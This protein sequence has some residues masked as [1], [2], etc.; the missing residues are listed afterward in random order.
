MEVDASHDKR[1]GIIIFGHRPKT[2][3]Y[4][5]GTM[6]STRTISEVK[7]SFIRNQVR[8]LSQA[9]ELPEDWKNY[10]VETEE[11]ELPEKVVGD[12]LHKGINLPQWSGGVPFAGLCCAAVHNIAAK[13]L[14]EEPEG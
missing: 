14:P 3:S 2:N 11:D 1:R 12:V 9:L 7:S 4:N 5:N 13:I 8:I 10:A 6:D